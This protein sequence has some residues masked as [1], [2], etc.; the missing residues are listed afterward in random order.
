MSVKPGQVTGECE[1]KALTVSRIP[2]S[3]SVGNGE[4]P[5]IL[6]SWSIANSNSLNEGHVC[7][8]VGDRTTSYDDYIMA[9]KR[10][11]S[12]GFNNP[13]YSEISYSSPGNI[14]ITK[15]SSS[16]VSA[17]MITS[18]SGFPGDKAPDTMGYGKEFF[19]SQVNFAVTDTSIVLSLPLLFHDSWGCFDEKSDLDY[20]G[21]AVKGFSEFL[22]GTVSV[23]FTKD[24]ENNADEGYSTSSFNAI[25]L[26]FEDLFN[27]YLNQMNC[28]IEEEPVLTS[29]GYSIC[30]SSVK[31]NVTTIVN[32]CPI[33]VLQSRFRAVGDFVNSD[34]SSRSEQWTDDLETIQLHILSNG[35]E[36]SSNI[37]TSTGGVLQTTTQ[38]GFSITEA[39]NETEWILVMVVAVESLLA[40]FFSMT[41]AIHSICN[42][43]HRRNATNTN[44]VINT[45]RM[46]MYKVYGT[47]CALAAWLVL[48]L[49]PVYIG[50]FSESDAENMAHNDVYLYTKSDTVCSDTFSNDL[51]SWCTSFGTNVQTLLVRT[52]TSTFVDRYMDL[53]IASTF[54]GGLFLIV[55]F[56]ANTKYVIG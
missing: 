16:V 10:E 43:A 48:G 35:V 13:M 55:I 41:Y 7:N 2:K 40:L 11:D 22:G 5:A 19:T 56:V 21:L 37:L 33:S 18:Y 27:Y 29:A 51:Q 20:Y 36:A 45:N 47:I 49:I 4:F 53:A 28:D 52:Y 34:F 15:I 12:Q 1:L 25:T 24:E 38:V 6:S 9:L 17:K 3:L 39:N 42:G 54:L 44:L 30:S 14:I 26:E 46:D 8:G 50:W 31:T 23:H 32:D